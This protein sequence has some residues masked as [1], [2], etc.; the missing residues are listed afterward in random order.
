M[1]HQT[2]DG[3]TCIGPGRT[4]IVPP[5]AV[6]A[7]RPLGQ[8]QV[9][10]AYYLAEW[11]AMDL[12]MLWAEPNLVP[13]FLSQSVMNPSTGAKVVEFDL[14]PEELSAVSRDLD[15]IDG[16]SQTAHTPNTLIRGAFLKVLARLSRA[17]LRTLPHRQYFRW[18]V[19]NAISHIERLVQTAAP[20]NLS[21][22]ADEAKLSTDYLA[23]LF[24]A[25]MG[26]TISDYF[27]LRRVHRACQLLMDPR[28]S[29]T[30]VALE[31]GYSDAPHFCR[32]FK[33]YRG[34][35]PMA[36]RSTYAPKSPE[37]GEARSSSS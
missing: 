36:Y 24:S 22:L 20:L 16:E 15:E 30:E 21:M 3:E 27:Q 23:K 29:I 13:L 4:I 1:L 25:A 28:L 19:Q 11:L 8:L 9:V 18:E 6:H 35:S 37:R 7:F 17:S 2:L 5:G 10:N 31:T 34:M 26:R 12:A 33:R 32:M 14:T